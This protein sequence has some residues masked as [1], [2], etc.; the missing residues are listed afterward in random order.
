MGSLQWW[1]GAGW[2][3]TIKRVQEKLAATA[4]YFSIGLLFKTLFMP[5]RQISAGKPR[6]P[7]AV[8][9]QAFVD[10]LVS[11]AIGAMI[12]TAIIGIGCLW[13]AIRVV[14]SGVFIV[15]WGIVPLLPI[16]GVVLMASGW[17]P[18]WNL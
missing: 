13:I 4:D 17:V 6:G 2:L 14:I 18:T 1:Y 9:W 11:R 5:F 8:R 12:R 16:V 3:Q 10:R 7:L 15:G